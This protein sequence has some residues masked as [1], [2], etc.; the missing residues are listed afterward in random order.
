MRVPALKSAT[1]VSVK[2]AICEVL[3]VQAKAAGVPVLPP[4]S[5]ARTWK[6]WLVMVRL[7]YVHGLSQAVK[8]P[9]SKLQLKVLKGL[10]DVKLKLATVL[11]V[12]GGGLAVMVVVGGVVSAV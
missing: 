1:E 7:L 2:I 4:A 12:S 8:E 3:M 6:V 11:F 10:L 5:V 9:P